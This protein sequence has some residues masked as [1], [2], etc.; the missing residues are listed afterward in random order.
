MM[1]VTAGWYFNARVV[2]QIA[3]S[4]AHAAALEKNRGGGTNAMTQA[5][6][7]IAAI[8]DRYKAR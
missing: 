5:A 3:D 8:N 6:L 2:Q 4:A 7:I 1:Q